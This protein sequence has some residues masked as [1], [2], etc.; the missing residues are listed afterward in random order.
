MMFWLIVA[1]VVVVGFAGAWWLSGR[2]KGSPSA[3]SDRAMRAQ[4]DNVSNPNSAAG[5]GGGPAG[6]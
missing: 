4:A 1:A 5:S 2:S 3:I 6:G